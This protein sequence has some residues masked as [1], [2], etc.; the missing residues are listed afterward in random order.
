MREARKTMALRSPNAAGYTPPSVPASYPCL[1]CGT[2]VQL[3]YCPECGQ[4]AIEPDPTLREFAHELAAELLNWD[5]KLFTTFRILFTMPG[6][7]TQE[8]LVGRRVSF[9]SPLR[10]YLTC[11]VLYFF[12][13]AVVP[14]SKPRPPK[15]G[16]VQTQIGPLALQASDSAGLARYL[17]STAHSANPTKRA[18]G[19][20]FRNALSRGAELPTAMKEALP[21]M[22]FVLVPFF[23]ALVALVFRTR[24]MHY[25]QHLAFALHV[26]AFMFVALL[27]SVAAGLIR[28]EGVK[29]ALDGVSIVA[30]ASYFVLAVR[31]VYATTVAGAI[32]RSAVIS[33]IYLLAYV[34]AVV[35]AFFALL[36]LRF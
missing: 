10:L 36:F 25:P 34:A 15:G 29:A 30:V 4:R 27:P 9:I 13:A 26:H 14:E 32:A 19:S 12:V 6:R 20:H 16:A 23:A 18:F 2:N 33:G 8:Y 17:D 35:V 11:S 1:N 3:R 24:R 7:L 21:K 5:G 28:N 31:R 22:M